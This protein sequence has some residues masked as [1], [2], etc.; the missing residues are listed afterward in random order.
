MVGYVKRSETP[1]MCVC[2][3]PCFVQ[4]MLLNHLDKIRQGL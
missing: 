2:A 4:F 1:E 3:I